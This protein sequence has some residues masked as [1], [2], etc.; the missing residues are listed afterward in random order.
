MKKEILAV[1]RGRL[2]GKR[3]K[4]YFTGFKPVESDEDLE[5]EKNMTEHGEYIP[6]DQLENNPEY[7]QIVTYCVLFNHDLN[8]IFS[9]KRAGSEKRLDDQWSI[10]IGGHIRQMAKPMD[11]VIRSNLVDNIN[12]EVAAVRYLERLQLMGYINCDDSPI[13][14]DHLGM[15]FFGEVYGSEEIRTVSPKILRGSF[16][17]PSTVER[18]M[19][20]HKFEDWSEI[21]YEVLMREEFRTA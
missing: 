6:R 7:K 21:A 19:K 20:Q 13:N 18:L 9:Y 12:R 8:A 5:L 16:R 4:G 15:L 10:G 14:R 1:Q 2:F 17:S 11:Q 3:R